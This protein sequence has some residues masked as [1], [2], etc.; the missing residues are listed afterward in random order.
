[1]VRGFECSFLE[2]DVIGDALGLDLRLFPFRFPVHGE[3]V[4]ERVELIKVAHRTLTAKGLIKGPRFDADLEDLLDVFARGRLALAMVG[5]ADGDNICARAVSDGRSAVLA[6]QQGQLI[7]FD[8]VT[9]PSMV[10]TLLSLLPR[11]RPGPG[12]SVTITVDEAAPSQRP[13]EEDF[14]G[15]RYLR[16]VEPVQDTASTQRAIA[17]DILRR[18]RLGSGY[19]TVTAK[20]RHGRDSEPLTMSWLDT[21]AG[22]YAVIPSTGADGRTHVTY[23]PADQA[24][25]D[26]SLSHL[27]NDLE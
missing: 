9:P 25:M 5:S 6:V 14:L 3:L 17:E 18:P 11:H 24:R 19:I 22:R 13:R 20:G 8:P 12:R 10:R 23:A 7:R 27:V 2:L 15:R 26:Q 4:D 1:V 16:P 21:E